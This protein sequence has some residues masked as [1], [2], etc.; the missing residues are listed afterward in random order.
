[1]AVCGG[2]WGQNNLWYGETSQ[3]PVENRS[4]RTSDHHRRKQLQHPWFLLAPGRA[5]E[6]KPS[7]F[8]MDNKFLFTITFHQLKKPYHRLST[9]LNQMVFPEMF[10]CRINHPLI[11]WAH[12]LRS[13]GFVFGASNVSKP[14]AF[15]PSSASNT[16]G[17]LSGWWCK[18][19]DSKGG[20]KR[21]ALVYKIQSCY[22]GNS[23]T[24]WTLVRK[25]FASRTSALL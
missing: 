10:S 2:G 14:A 23:Y 13:R 15:Q 4:G 11:S 1:M 17:G 5:K 8:L 9:Y 18:G 7:C 20:R 3:T 24:N 22:T 16:Q 19:F 12:H 25:Y 21:W 6:E